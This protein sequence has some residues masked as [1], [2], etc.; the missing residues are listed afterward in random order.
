MINFSVFLIFFNFLI[1]ELTQQ[2]KLIVDYTFS[3]YVDTLDLTSKRV[4]EKSQLY[5]FS[6]HSDYI[7]LGSYLRDSV[8]EE[9]AKKTGFYESLKTSNPIPIN[10]RE[11][12]KS[13]SIPSPY[14]KV[15]VRKQSGMGTLQIINGIVVNR[16]LCYRDTLQ[17]KWTITGLEDTLLGIKVLEATTVFNNRFFSAW[18]APELPIQ[19]GPYKFFGLPGLILKVS[20][21]NDYFK[22]EAK[23]INSGRKIFSYDFKFSKENEYR[24]ISKNLVKSMMKDYL[25]SPEV[26]HSEL[27]KLTPE[28]VI[29]IRDNVKKYTFFS[30]EL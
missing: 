18:F 17:F 13:I 29:K 30:L 25:K 4:E 5:L 3:F 2:P 27:Y 12:N 8:F 9:F 7:Q 19:D 14:F 24:F 21:S 28:E 11:L 20:D 6:G 22:F 26:N 10:P 1:D 23:S 16:Q 15:A